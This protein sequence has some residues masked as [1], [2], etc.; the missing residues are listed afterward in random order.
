MKHTKYI[1]RVFVGCL[2][3]LTACQK[4]IDYFVPDPIQPP[5]ED[6]NWVAN[7]TSTMPV[8]I[9][10]DSLLLPLQNDSFLMGGSLNTQYLSPSGM[11]FTFQRN[12]IQDSVFQ[13]VTGRVH[14]QTLLLKKKGD[15]IRANVNTLSNRGIL[16]AGAAL[17]VQLSKQNSPLQIEPNSTFAV[18][19][20]VNS[21]ITNSSLFYGDYNIS[22]SFIWQSS[23]D[24]SANRVIANSQGYELFSR[25]LGWISPAKTF[26]TAAPAQ[27]RLEMNLESQYTNA[28]TMVYLVMN[29]V[30]TVL[31]VRGEFSIKKFR[32]DLVPAGVPVSVVVI[33]K[34]GNT[35]YSLRESLSTIASGG[36][37]TQVVRLQPRAASLSSI[38]ELLDNL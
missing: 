18:N 4:D 31:P 10:R 28:N 32:S 23:L 11:R 16:T 6:T 19:V 30:L 7:I 12:S 22:T 5:R 15:F 14:I 25:P 24:S 13:V 33:S 1:F 34:Q 2:F 3:I 26:V 20:P 38:I 29:N 37:S 35:Y 9:L 36:N 17:F 8:S 27:T 21:P